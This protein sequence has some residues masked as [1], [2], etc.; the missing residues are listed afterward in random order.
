[1][2]RT[3]ADQ[4]GTD[5]SLFHLP[6]YAVHSDNPVFARKSPSLL[7]ER[8]RTGEELLCEKYEKFS[9]ELFA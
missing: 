2:A 6:P 8:L 1:V 5:P 9:G 7:R 4:N 3:S